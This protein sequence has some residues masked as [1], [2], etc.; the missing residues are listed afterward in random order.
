MSLIRLPRHNVDLETIR[1]Y[2]GQHG[3]LGGVR[4]VTLQNGAECGIRVIEFTT[5]AGLRF[6]L[7][8]E[9][10]MDIG[11]AEYRGTAIGW[12]LPLGSD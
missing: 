7:L 10:A 1:R 3:V 6:D 8:V 4:L 5:A 11:L 12:R 9:R 2:G